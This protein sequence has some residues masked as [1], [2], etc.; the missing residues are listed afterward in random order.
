MTLDRATLEAAGGNLRRLESDVKRMK[1]TNVR[2][3]QDE[4]ARLAAGL[5]LVEGGALGGAHAP[6]PAADASS[7]PA[8]AAAS[9]SSSSSAAAP[10]AAPAG[11]AAAGTGGEE[12]PAAPVLPTDV[13]EQ[14]IPGNIRNAVLFIRFMRLVVRFLKQRIKV[15]QVE[16]ETPTAF[17]HRMHTT[18]ALDP[19]PLKFAYSRLN[20]LLRTLEIT[21]MDGFAPLNLVADF[22]TLITTYPKGFMVILEPFNSRTPHIPDPIMQLACLG[23]TAAHWAEAGVTCAEPPPPATSSLPPPTPPQTRRW[24]CAPCFRSSSRSS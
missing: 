10:V 2:R 11:V 9:S 5:G 7:A 3:L 20:S 22:A 24:P 23:E 21:D 12:L 19:R 18:T 17:L 13:A 16:T 4:Y 15:A 8:A 6:G 14:A 1:E